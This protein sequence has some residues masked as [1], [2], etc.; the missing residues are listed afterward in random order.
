MQAIRFETSYPGPEEGPI[1][2]A[3]SFNNWHAGDPRYRLQRIGPN[4]A[5]TELEI[6]EEWPETIEYKYTRGDWSEVEIDRFGNPIHNRQVS[7]HTKSQHDEV[8]RWTVGGQFYP[9]RFLPR[10]EAIEEPF[11]IPR[12]IRTR[13]ITALLP[14]NYYET[15]RRYPVLYLQD[16]QNLFDDYAPFGNW[17]VDKRLAVL[18]EI[19]LGDVIVIA[20]DHAAE[21]RVKEFTPSFRTRLGKGQGK[22]YTRFL[23]T[24]LKPYVDKRFRTLVGR[25]HTGIG[26]S[27]LGGLISI[28][29]GMMF[30][31][32][33]S[34]L[35]IFSPSLWVVPQIPF[36]LLQMSAEFS[37]RI[38]L[39]GGGQ[40]GETMI[41]NLERFRSQLRAQTRSE[42]VQF[43][44][45]I[46][47]FGQHN[48]V[49]WGQEF[50]RALTW[51]YYGDQLL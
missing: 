15:D 35:M 18:S 7:K 11:A 12:L 37:G 49:R 31:E 48:E 33:F 28:Y 36:H 38:Y 43:E 10:I 50:P 25:A 34:K 3:G 23:T 42:H 27:S 8:A 46:D 26:G 40:E 4:R 13:R 9:G 44:L 14:Y 41:P 32:V 45:T 21:E 47:P 20:I 19:G 29:A 30:P 17:A 39:Y 16:G 1:Y 51:L 24:V 2:L 22:T 6:L 5:A